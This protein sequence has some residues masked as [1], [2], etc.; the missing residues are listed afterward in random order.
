VKKTEQRDVW[1]D[2]R[3]V[4]QSILIARNPKFHFL[5][6]PCDVEKKI[7]RLI[8]GEYERNEHSQYFGCA[9]SDFQDESRPKFLPTG[10]GLMED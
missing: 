2:N 5:K 7:D 6:L 3:L 1:R 10:H 8:S 9:F 4:G